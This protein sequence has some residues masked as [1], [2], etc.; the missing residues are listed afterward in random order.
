[1]KAKY[2]LFARAKPDFIWVD[3]DVRQSHHS[4][5]YPCFCPICLGMFG[6]GNDRAALVKRMNDP[7]DGTTLTWRWTK[8]TARC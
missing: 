2:Q 8:P 5:T 4:V 1:M 3:D 6:R 7:A